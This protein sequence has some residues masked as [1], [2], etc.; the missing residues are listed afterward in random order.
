MKN[1]SNRFFMQLK[2]SCI[3][4]GHVSSIQ[5]LSDQLPFDDV[6]NQYL[7]HTGNCA[8]QFPS[9]K[10]TTFET[11]MKNPIFFNFLFESVAFVVL[12]FG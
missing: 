4:L 2:S 1:G 7:F 3:F 12:F 8:S 9:S 6:L 11:N 5:V 10:S